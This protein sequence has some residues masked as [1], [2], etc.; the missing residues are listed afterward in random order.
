MANL[1]TSTQ[2]HVVRNGSFVTVSGCRLIDRFI[3]GLKGPSS[4]IVVIFIAVVR[5]MQKDKNV[6]HCG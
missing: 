6:R 5:F 4:L 3:G 1:D 2:S